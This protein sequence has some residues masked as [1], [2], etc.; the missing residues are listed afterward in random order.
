MS[1]QHTIFSKST[2]VE[3]KESNRYKLTDDGKFGEKSGRIRLRA[4]PLEGGENN[5]IKMYLNPSE[6]YGFGRKIAEA[7]HGNKGNAKVINHKFEENTST[8]SIDVYDRNRGKG[9]PA[10]AYALVFTKSTGDLKV[11][12][13]ISS[14]ELHFLS[15]LLKKAGLET[16]HV[17]PMTQPEIKWLKERNNGNKTGKKTAQTEDPDNFSEDYLPGR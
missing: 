17:T 9:D 5:Q 2:G 6:A 7:V 8:V 4:F 10:Y 16:A 13:P 15:D 12:I 11:N 3:V 1:L 14:E